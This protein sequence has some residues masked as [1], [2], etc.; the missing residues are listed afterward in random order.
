MHQL[1]QQVQHLIGMIV[2]LRSPAVRDERGL[3]QSAENAILL[4][5]AVA[6]ATI[7]IGAITIYVTNHMPK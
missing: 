3:S 6:V 1:R 7:V 5:G 2:S 4:A